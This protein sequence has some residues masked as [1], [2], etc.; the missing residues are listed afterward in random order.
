MG[1]A[2]KNRACPAA[3]HPITPAECGEGRGSRF[4]CPADCRFNPFAPANYSQLLQ[5]EQELDTRSLD[6][7][8]TESRDR[9]ALE[10]DIQQARSA[11]SGH[12]LHA[13]ISWRFLFQTDGHSLTSAQRLDR[14]GSQRLINDHRVLLR[15]KMQTRVA[16]LEV[17]RVPDLEQTE[18]VDLLAAQPEPFV[19]RDRGLAG[20]AGRFAAFLGWLYP[21]PH[22]H[23]LSGTAIL[24]PDLLVFEPTEIVTEIVRHLGGATDEAGMRHWLA[25][26]FARFDQ[27]L[28]AV[29]LERRRLMFE[30]MDAQFGKAVYE[31]RRPFADCRDG[32]DG[33]AD[34]TED[35]LADGEQTE[36]FAEARVW[37]AGKGD[38]E[39]VGGGLGTNRVLGRVLLG[40]AHWRLE[41]MGGAKLA[42]LRQRFERTMGD[43]VR[44]SG[45]RLDDMAAN[46]AQKDP[47]PDLSLVPPKL[48]QNPQ[49][50]RLVTSR[51]DKPGQPI[52]TRQLTARLLA[53]QERAWLDESIEALGGRTPRAAARD[54]QWRSALIR[55]M[56]SRVRACDERNLR[57]GTNWDVNWMLRELGLT[58]ILFD[59]PPAHRAPRRLP[60]ELDDD[61]CE[62][63]F[64][65]ST[66]VDEVRSPR[67]DLPASPPLPPGPFTEAQV[68][69][70]LQELLGEFGSGARTIDAV[71][72]EGCTL[73]ATVDEVTVP[74]LD[75]AAFT[76]LAPFLAMVW[77]VFVPRG[78]CGPRVDPER[79]IAG[80]QRDTKG[81]IKMLEARSEAAFELQFRGGRQPALTEG[82]AGLMLEALDRLPKKERPKLHT[83][84]L[85][86]AV[87]RAVIEEMDSACR[88]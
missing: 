40:Q 74:L 19:V 21:L 80:I 11:K 25:G 44:F 5:I 20:V 63:D 2:S 86:I 53:E 47:K 50:I 69:Q 26:N 16:L 65:D 38:E 22:F 33:V 85:M 77:E 66:V 51:V 88:A 75:D 31:L 68:N 73:I 70:K 23:R 35:D 30:G 79:L 49:R 45:E 58:E 6:W 37:F 8:I 39:L 76:L 4:A 71:E 72:A 18:V 55:L 48:L 17:R 15:A 3:G 52:S 36:G 43:R 41:A 32:L 7:L 61:E 56:K 29:S 57:A 9:A 14:D 27:A 67:W 46:M 78:T 81:L 87:L 54:E 42:A 64:E 83:E 34:V 59:P 13:L 24:L 82:L 62:G 10:R 60:E 12:A 84:V 1:R 28:T